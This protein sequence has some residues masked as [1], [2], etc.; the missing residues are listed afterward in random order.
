MAGAKR[1]QLIVKKDFQYR[2]FFE[3]TIFM[4]FVAILVGW[5]VYLGIFKA[6]IF[7]LSGEKIT[8]IHR[9]ISIRML[10]WFLPTVFSIVIISVFLSHQIAGPIF[11]FQRT[12]KE[13]SEGKS[14]RKI[15]LRDNDR[16]KDFA[17]DLNRLVDFFNSSNNFE[18]EKK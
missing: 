7:E 4:F 6:L 16:L 2:I 8:L 1:R 17:D 11:V 14:P 18:L 12:I 3:T 10:M 5:T 13:I 9:L 15:H